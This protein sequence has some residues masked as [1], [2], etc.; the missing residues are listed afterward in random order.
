MAGEVVAVLSPEPDDEDSDEAGL[1]DSLPP[2]EDE[3]SEPDPEAGSRDELD[4]PE[5][6]FEPERLS[7]L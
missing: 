2:D 6:D 4:V 3:L 1:E 5:D 7:V